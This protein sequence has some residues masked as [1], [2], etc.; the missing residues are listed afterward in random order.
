MVE[1]NLD[2]LEDTVGRNMYVEG[3]SAA[4]I[5]WNKECHFRTINTFG[6]AIHIINWQKIWL[7]FV[8][9]LDGK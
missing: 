2:C 4:D 7:Y 5:R 8:L 9:F 3:S 6:K 1:K